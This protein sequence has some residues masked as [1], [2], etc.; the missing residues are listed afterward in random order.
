MSEIF[1]KIYFGPKADLQKYNMCNHRVDE[2][3]YRVPNLCSLASVWERSYHVTV[4][5][6]L[7]KLLKCSVTV[8]DV[9]HGT[10]VI[11]K[12]HYNTRTII[13][14]STASFF[15]LILSQ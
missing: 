2:A 8:S 5:R 3:S 12:R 1:C 13:P 9:L 6:L 11:T 7:Q 15:Y 4:L 14:T 10:L